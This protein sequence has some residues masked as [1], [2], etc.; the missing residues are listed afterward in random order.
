MRGMF[1]NSVLEGGI[2]FSDEDGY[3]QGSSWLLSRSHVLPLGIRYD[4][5]MVEEQDQPQKL[6][7]KR[8]QERASARKRR[9]EAAGNA[10]KQFLALSSL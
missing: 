10:R 8:N 3:F 5:I 7:L 4:P 1:L 9:E 6:L 2:A